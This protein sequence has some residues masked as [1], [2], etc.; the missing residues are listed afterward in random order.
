MDLKRVVHV[1]ILS[2][3][4]GTLPGPKFE[5]VRYGDVNLNFKNDG[6]KFKRSVRTKNDTNV[7]LLK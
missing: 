6:N 7:Q 2:G 1:Y 4:V 5:L 3:V